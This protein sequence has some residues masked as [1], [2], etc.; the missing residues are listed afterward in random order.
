MHRRSITAASDSGTIAFRFAALL[1]M[2]SGAQ[3]GAQQAST[4]VLKQ[5]ELYP[6]TRVRGCGSHLD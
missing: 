3:S 4:A 2:A 5:I 6:S 1:L